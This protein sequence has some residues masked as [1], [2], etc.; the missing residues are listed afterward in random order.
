M[1]PFDLPAGAGIALLVVVLWLL[2]SH[3]PAA[4]MEEG[5]MLDLP[6][7]VLHGAAIDR[8]FEYFYGPL[9]IWLPSG[10]YWAFGASLATERAVGDFYLLVLG[11][12]LFW[13]GR[14]RSLL[15]GTLMAAGAVVLEQFS[16]VGLITALPVVGAIGFSVLGVAIGSS[17]RDD[18]VVDVGAGLALA[19][20]AA[21]R[22]D[23][24]V[25]SLIVAAGLVK[26][27]FRRT[28]LVAVYLVGAAMSYL[29][30]V[31][32]AG[33]GHVWQA[34]VVNSL[35]LPAERRL[36][37]ARAGQ[38]GEV[39]AL[40]LAIV[41]VVSGVALWRSADRYFARTAAL[42]ALLCAMVV[43]EFLQRAELM[44]LA[45]LGGIVVGTLPSVAYLALGL[46]VRR[47]LARLLAVVVTVLGTFVAWKIVDNLGYPRYHEAWDG[48]PLSYAVSNDGRIWYYPSEYA[49]GSARSVITLLDAIG[50]KASPVMVAP[51]D[52]A[53]TWY[54]DNSLYFLLPQL[55]ENT[56]F[57]DFHPGI[58]LHEGTRLAADVRSART[59][60]LWNIPNPDEANS[61]REYGSELANEVVRRDFHLVAH[62]GWYKV[63]TRRHL[64]Q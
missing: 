62:F 22:P 53:R 1:G 11:L 8:S 50:P 26:L 33:L 36:P 21:L 7:R 13:I 54:S 15:L 44:H 55:W 49:A 51:Q 10:V 28:T 3:W 47:P 30:V 12:S 45:T 23:F 31:T 20:S 16:S 48:R 60:I 64:G 27:K 34:I 61:S 37:L 5:Y 41:L 56:H 9:S 18:Q 39:V 32:Q 52:L 6:L 46:D 57:Y 24:A 2:Q 35:R 58:S 42:L 25:W 14:R 19:V 38:P 4:F 59:L 29:I 63:Y 40:L 43:P 17:R